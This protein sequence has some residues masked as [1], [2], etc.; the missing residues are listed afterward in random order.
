MP[1]IKDP[2]DTCIAQLRRLVDQWRDKDIHPDDII[3][4]L[5][6][7]ASRVAW[8]KEKANA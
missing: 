7:E 6:D 4:M 2:V 1:K 8:R 3:E 5:K